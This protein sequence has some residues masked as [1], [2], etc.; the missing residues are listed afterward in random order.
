LACLR[1]A[2]R[3]QHECLDRE[4]PLAQAGAGLDDYLHHAAALHAWLSGLAPELRALPW[5]APAL[6]WGLPQQLERLHGDLGDAGLVPAPGCP[7]STAAVAQAMARHGA[8]AEAVRWGLAYVVEGS[9]LGGQVLYR[10]LAGRLAPHPLRYLRGSG[11]AT[12]ARWRAFTAALEAHVRGPAPTAA[13]CD[14]A[15]A[16]FGVLQTLLR[17]PE[18][19]A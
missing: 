10:R 18:V 1:A 4:L 11:S 12:G 5:R 3:V 6:A 9:Q 7:A 13:A 14:G 15:R 19:A 16:A 8:Q 2:T 17:T